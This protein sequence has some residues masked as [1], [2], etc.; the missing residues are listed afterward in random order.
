MNNE[1]RS[2]LTI[3]QPNRVTN[4]KYSYN[5]REE[6]I[7]TLMIDAVQKHMS[8]EQKIQTDLF[9]DPM[10]TLDMSV[11]SPSNKK[12]YLNAAE[13]MMKKVFNFSYTNEEGRLEDV[14]GVLITTVRNERETSKIHIT[15]NSWAIPYL[16]YVGKG[17]GGTIY[18]KAIA[19]TL[20]GKY[21]KRMYKMCKRWEDKKG[22]SMGLDEFRDKFELKDLYS[23][24]KDLKKRV[25]DASRDHLKEGA[26]VYFEYSMAKIGGSRKYNQINFVVKGNNK[27]KKKK[28][29]T[30]LYVFVYNMLCIAW[31]V[32]DSSKAMEECDRISE[33]PDKLESL[34][35]R[36]KKLRGDLEDGSKTHLDVSKLIKYI[37]KN[38]Y[39][40]LN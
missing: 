12:N 28:E 25:L 35:R 18:N 13:S 39:E 29:K 2:P 40:Y 20:P 22:F 38:D 15:I 19:L 16:L 9:N 1:K 23:N 27:R 21:S 17:V 7:L 31:P 8:Q 14:S 5:E 32:V 6:N 4:A 10:I 24:V 11:I 34:Y 37:I 36:L 3:I 26:D 33:N 30:D